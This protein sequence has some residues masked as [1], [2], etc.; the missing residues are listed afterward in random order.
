MLFARFPVGWSLYELWV[1]SIGWGIV[2]FPNCLW[3]LVM[4]G[5]YMDRSWPL[6]LCALHIY[7]MRMD[8]TCRLLLAF[9]S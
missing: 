6:W 5:E 1:Y 9:F 7:V 3:F 2:L 8:A 4:L